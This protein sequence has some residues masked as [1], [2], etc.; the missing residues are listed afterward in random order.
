MKKWKKPFIKCLIFTLGFIAVERLCHLATDGFS[1]ARIQ[2]VHIP[3]A[4]FN[5][6]Q[7]NALTCAILSQPFTYYASGSQSFAF[8]SSDGQ[9]ILKFFK[10]RPSLYSFYKQKKRYH[11]FKRCFESCLY[12]QK[13]FQKESGVVYCHLAP[14]NFAMPIATLIDPSGCRLHQPLNSVP[15]VLQKRAEMTSQRFLRF[16]QTEDIASAKRSIDHLLNLMVKRYRLG[17]SD[18]D[19]NWINNFGFIDDYPIS[20]DIGGLIADR[21]NLKHY[22]L[23][24]ELTKAEEKAT[25]WLKVHH[26]ELIP[27][28]NEK[29]TDVKNKIE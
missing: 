14:S 8:L 3:E 28:L 21:P 27:Y 2:P 13:F 18:K 29:F 11:S 12:H 6:K 22:F 25:T 9:Y 20:L 19:P 16:K 24:R 4:H 26:P 15:F 17:F 23:H 1:L 10:L 5:P 7:P